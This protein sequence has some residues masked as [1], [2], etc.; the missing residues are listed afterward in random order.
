ME[1]LV[2]SRVRNASRRAGISKLALPHIDGDAAVFPTFLS[3][4]SLVLGSSHT[5]SSISIFALGQGLASALGR[6]WVLRIFRYHARSD[7]P[8]PPPPRLDF[9]SRAIAHLVSVLDVKLCSYCRSTTSPLQPS[10]RYFPVCK[11]SLAPLSTPVVPPT[12]QGFSHILGSIAATNP[13]EMAEVHFA[14]F[15]VDLHGALRASRQGLGTTVVTKT[16]RAKLIM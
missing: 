3:P 13:D 8:I 14:V 4:R 7:I 5:V 6:R 15:G 12:V 11:R 10:W 16:H 2:R 9:V 1:V